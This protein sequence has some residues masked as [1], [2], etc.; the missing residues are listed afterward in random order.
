[1]IPWHHLRSGDSK[2]QSHHE[3]H[4]ELESSGKQGG[5]QLQVKSFRQETLAACSSSVL[6]ASFIFTREVIGP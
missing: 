3:L 1:M 4:H 2:R 5:R 6:S